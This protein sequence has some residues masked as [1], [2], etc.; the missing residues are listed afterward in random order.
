MDNENETK[1]TRRYNYLII[2]FVLY[3]CYFVYVSLKS[4]CK[5]LI[6]LIIDVVFFL[7]FFP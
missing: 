7:P 6:K 2:T 4:Y 5:K 3:F 1:L